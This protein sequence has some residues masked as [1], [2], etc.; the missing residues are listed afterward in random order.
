[1]EIKKVNCLMVLVCLFLSTISGFSAVNQ[2]EITYPPKPPETTMKEMVD[3]GKGLVR[4][5]KELGGAMID[6]VKDDGG[7]IATIKHH[8][9]FYGSIFIFFVLFLCWLRGRTK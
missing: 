9:K 3:A 5:T 2:E 1:M 4:E 7:I 8:K 6:G